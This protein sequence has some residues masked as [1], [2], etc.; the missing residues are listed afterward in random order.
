MFIDLKFH[1]TGFDDISVRV[2]FEH[3]VNCFDC[4][5][6]KKMNQLNHAVILRA[7]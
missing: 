7:E 4:A 1:F 5:F 2:S 3:F 6:Y